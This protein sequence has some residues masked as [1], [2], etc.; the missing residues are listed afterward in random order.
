MMLEDGFEFLDILGDI[1]EQHLTRILNLQDQEKRYGKIRHLG[2]IAAGIA[3]IVLLSLCGIFHKQVEAAAQKIISY[4]AGV[5]GIEED[6]TPYTEIV[7]TAIEKEGI[8]VCLEEVVVTPNAVLVAVSVEGAPEDYGIGTGTITINGTKMVPDRSVGTSD[9]SET[10]KTVH[11]KCW[12][13]FETIPYLDENKIQTEVHISKTLEDAFAMRYIPFAFEFEISK[14][15]IYKDSLYKELN[16]KIYINESLSV[17][18]CSYSNNGLNGRIEIETDP[19][20][21]LD[22]ECSYFLFGVTD[23]GDEK[24][25]DG[26]FETDGTYR[27]RSLDAIPLDCQWLELQL[28]MY[29]PKYENINEENR[30][31]DEDVVEQESEVYEI[32]PANMT[33]LGDPVRI[34]LTE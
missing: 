2:R 5:L 16:E 13:F 28:Y 33:P 23:T 10:M 14:S 20:N 21:G 29:R 26:A 32:N 9:F 6:L 19:S 22:R 3:L 7:G 34:N 1:D 24:Q 15:D 27:F 17:N 25:F 30:T 11:V 18:I 12:E 31:E 4:I 8:T